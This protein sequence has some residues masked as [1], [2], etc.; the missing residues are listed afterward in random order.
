ML[1]FPDCSC[2]VGLRCA[3]CL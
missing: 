1:F 3:N 2:C